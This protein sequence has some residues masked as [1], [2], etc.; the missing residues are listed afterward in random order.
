MSGRYALFSGGHDSL[1][2]THK[3][4]ESGDADTV[5]HIDTGIGIPETQEFVKAT[6]EKHDWWLE[7]VESEFDYEDV[8]L[9]EQFPGP[10]VHIIMYSKLKERALRKVARWHDEKPT[11]I[12]GVRSNESERRFRNVD[13]VQ[14]AASW[15]WKANIHSWSQQKVESYIDD[16]ELARSPVKQKYHHSGECLCGAFGNRTEELTLLEAHYPDTAERIKQLEDKVQAE[17]G[18]DD[19]RSYWAHGDMDDKQMRT[20]L[21]D[22]DESQM[23]LCASCEKGFQ[24]PENEK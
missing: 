8:V 24:Q 13:E 20:L 16:H 3:A 18:S 10:A 7:I 9:E 19:P 5:L 14:E 12:T 11:F 23:M 21:A 4:M 15:V 17:H 6:C 22:N 2:S 1:V